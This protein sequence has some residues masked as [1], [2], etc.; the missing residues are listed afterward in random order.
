MNQLKL[1]DNC[2][3]EST[4]Q[5]EEKNQLHLYIDGASR[6]NPGPAGVGIYLFN[7]E[8]TL[9]SQGFYL[10]RKTNNQA[11]YYALLLGVFFA[12][13][14]LGPNDVLYIFSDSQLLVRQITGHYKI[15]NIELKK[16]FSV[17][18]S[19]LS[20]FNYHICHILRDCNKKADALANIGIDR[21]MEVPREFTL[22]LRTYDITL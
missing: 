16:I 19:L 20:D 5:D 13:K 22:L 21:K 1:F 12:K 6:N 17:V 18:I 3:P 7:D 8:K 10:G 9:V 2:Y 4:V 11:E 14:F 15:K